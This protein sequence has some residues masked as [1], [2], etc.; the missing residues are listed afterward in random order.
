MR[1]I[2]LLI[3][4]TLFILLTVLSS[5]GQFETK[6]T[7]FKSIKSYLFHNP[8]EIG[9][10]KFHTRVKIGYGLP[11]GIVGINGEFG[12]DRLAVTAGIGYAKFRNTSGALG[13]HTGFRGYISS[14]EKKLRP[15]V[16]AHYGLANI[17]NENGVSK[18]VYGPTIGIG[19][20]HKVTDFIVYDLEYTFIINP[21][22]TYRPTNK[23]H[24]NIALPHFGIG[25][26]F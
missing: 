18:A 13:F 2:A 15:R 9:E 7:K 14:N 10:L 17:Y 24:E 6:K 16:S 4:P 3:L 8:L 19:F 20:E 1:K 5:F 11:Q 25:V 12:L 23:T 22:N 26:Y 21:L